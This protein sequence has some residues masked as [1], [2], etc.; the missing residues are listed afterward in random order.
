MELFDK[1]ANTSSGYA[2]IIFEG[3]LFNL[4][5]EYTR[6]YKGGKWDDLNI[7]GAIFYMLPAAVDGE[8]VSLFNPNNY[9][10]DLV[11]RET[12]SVALC[13]M[14]LNFTIRKMHDRGH[15]IASLINLQDS[16]TDIVYGSKDKLN[17]SAIA[18]FLD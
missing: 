9:F 5:E 14:A 16:M 1:I 13:L 10:D 11:S 18:G 2:A 7:N 4:A 6:G 12:A 3:I 8:P 15:N 17:T